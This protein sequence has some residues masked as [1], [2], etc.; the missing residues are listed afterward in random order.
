MGP[1]E[2]LLEIWGVDSKGVVLGLLVYGGGLL[3][4][5]GGLLVY[6]GG[7]VLGL[8]VYKGGLLVYGGLMA[9]GG[10]KVEEE[11]LSVG[12]DSGTN[13]EEEILSVG[14]DSGTALLLVA[15]FTFCGT[16]ASKE[17]MEPQSSCTGGEGEESNAGLREK[18]EGEEEKPPA[19]SPK[20]REGG[21][22]TAARSTLIARP[23][24]ILP[25]ILE[26]AVSASSS[27]RKVTKP[28]PRERPLSRSMTIRTSVTSPW[29]ANALRRAS[30]WVRNDRPPTNSLALA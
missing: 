17:G 19:E 8:L 13:A 15:K 20:G 22:R 7:E 21:G 24:K 10:S 2:S 16:W 28:K 23:S 29:A 30:S 27:E 4:Y 6:G 3:V 1:K 9:G 11:K 25:F 14:L 18:S 12:F 5:G 26:K